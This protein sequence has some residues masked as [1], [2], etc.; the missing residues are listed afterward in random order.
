[1]M[2]HTAPLAWP[3]GWPTTPGYDRKSGGFQVTYEEAA[4]QLADELDRLGVTDGFISTDQPVRISGT[5]DRTRQPGTPG[6]AVY[7]ER[8]G[9]SLCIPCDKFSSVRDNIRAVGLTLESIRRMERYGTS[10]TVEA[11]M[12]GFTA[13]PA[14]AGPSVGPRAWH[15]VLG[16]A[17]DSPASVIRAAYKAKALDAHPDRGG[18]QDAW[19]ELQQ[20]FDQSGAK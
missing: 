11:A 6:V 2:R 17:P 5:P 10:Q 20:A 14:T 16:V 12:S 7:F 18:S 1:M 4:S 15:D 9:K 8:H 13:I 3:V 19:L